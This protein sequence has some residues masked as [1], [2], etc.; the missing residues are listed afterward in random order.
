MK[1]YKTKEEARAVFYEGEHPDFEPCIYIPRECPM[2]LH[3]ES[4]LPCGN[5]CAWFSIREITERDPGFN[6]PGNDERMCGDYA[7]CKGTPIQ[8]IEEK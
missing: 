4:P 1:T 8:K 5:W 2:D 7:C 3:G 6:L